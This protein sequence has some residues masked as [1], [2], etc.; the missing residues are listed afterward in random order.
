MRWSVR[1]L[2]LAQVLL[3]LA[4]CAGAPTATPSASTAAVAPGSPN[5][6]PSLAA[7]AS[8][9]PAPSDAPAVEPSPSIGATH[10]AG[11]EPGLYAEVVAGNLRIRSKP[12]VSDDSEKLEPLLQEGIRLLVIEGPVEASGYDWFHVQ[13]SGYDKAGHNYPSGWVAA[14][15]AGEHWI[16]PFEFDCPPVPEDVEGLTELNPWLA[17]LDLYYRISCYGGVEIV[18]TARLEQQ[19]APCTGE[20]SWAI[21]PAWF[22]EGCSGYHHGLVSLKSYHRE[23]GAWAPEVDLSMAAEPGAPPE[24]WPTVEV[25]GQFDHPAARTC[26]RTSNLEGT[27]DY[28]LPALTILDCRTQFVVTSMRE[29]NGG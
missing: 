27:P 4:G 9:S 16:K 25:T 22:G 21:E 13:P 24:D 1:S 20:A 2:A 6:S 17:H 19:A 5:P 3:V 8:L 7:R 14:G 11:V 12:R 15:K 28:R 26:T 29:V 10:V 23:G 18:F